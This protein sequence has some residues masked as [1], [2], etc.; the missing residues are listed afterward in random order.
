MPIGRNR[1]NAPYQNA[2]LRAVFPVDRTSVS[3]PA[4]AE[5]GTDRFRARS[6]RMRHKA[7]KNDRERQENDDDLRTW[8]V[9][10]LI[11]ITVT[12]ALYLPLIWSSM[13]AV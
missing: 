9:I 13:Y 3:E 7:H 4:A 12:L 2:S 11:F 8:V 5:Q 10:G 1:W 6:P